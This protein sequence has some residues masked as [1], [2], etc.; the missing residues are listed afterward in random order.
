MHYKVK[1]FICKD[2][3]KGF[4]NK[5]N[6]IVHVKRLHRNQKDKICKDCGKAYLNESE[7]KAHE[8]YVHMKI[9]EHTRDKCN[10][11]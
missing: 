5:N 3:G 7:L 8:R 2:C 11:G 1:D 9:I 10:R 4:S 6:M